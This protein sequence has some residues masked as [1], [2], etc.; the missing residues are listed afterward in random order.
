MTMNLRQFFNL[1][2]QQ[3]LFSG[4]Y[5]TSTALS[6]ALTMTLFLVVYIMV[7]PVY[8]EQKRGRM[9]VVE[10]VKYETRDGGYQ[11][12]AASIA[13]ADSLRRMPEVECLTAIQSTDMQAVYD[14][15]GES[16]LC[17]PKQVDDA[18]WQVFDFRFVSGRAFTREEYEA[19]SPVCVI[20]EGLARKVFG[21]ADV[22]GGTLHL[23]VTE[24][25]YYTYR[26]DSLLQIVGVVEDVSIA[27]PM[28][29]AQLWLPNGEDI[30]YIYDNKPFLGGS[31]LAMLLR[32]GATIDGLN[33][34]V[35]RFEERVNQEMAAAG[36]ACSFSIIGGVLPQWQ[37]GLADVDEGDWH[38]I[39]RKIL[40]LLLAFLLIPAMNMSSM[41]ASRI[42]ARIGEMGIRRAYGASRATLLWQVLQE[43]FLLTL[44]GSLLGLALSWLIMTLGAGWLPFIFQTQGQYMAVAADMSV[45]IHADMLFSGWVLVAVLVAT[46]VLNLISALVPTMW[47]LHKQ[48]T[49]E[50]NHKR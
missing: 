48:V 35:A 2:R 8:P 30:Y 3:R 24:T 38:P 36:N 7:G 27:T 31:T 39:L 15:H 47:I 9:A 23:E 50:I 11:I 12:S 6:T 26:P 28:A 17:L 45:Q 5:I 14:S 44:V 13:L 46:L 25:P 10:R 1:L 49:E 33:E 41:V 18:Y 29:C 42:N 32:E 34:R 37:H 22:A 19:K 20:S 40:G 4:I 43:N 16:F 21:R